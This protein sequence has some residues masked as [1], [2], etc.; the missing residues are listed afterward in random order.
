MPHDNMSQSN[1]PGSNATQASAPQASTRLPTPAPIREIRGADPRALPAAVLDGFEPVVLRGLV[2]DWP[3]V[4]AGLSGADAASAYL[5]RFYRGAPVRALVGPPDIRGR[6]FYNED[7]SGFNFR[8]GQDT[9]DR[10]LAALDAVAQAHNSTPAQVALAW[11]IA[12]P[13]LTA[14][15]ASATSVAQIT[16]E[17]VGSLTRM[18]TSGAM[19]TMGVT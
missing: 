11:Q 18:M 19:A 5:L 1:L 16:S 7:L 8:Q 10:V 4:Q 3:L 17:A 12:R 15:I 6:F 13:G 2:A 14:P 9:L